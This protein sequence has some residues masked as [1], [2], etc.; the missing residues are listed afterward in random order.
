IEPFR[1]NL[2]TEQALPATVRAHTVF[3][4]T[5]FRA[6]QTVSM[7]H[8]IRAETGGGFALLPAGQ[9]P[10]RLRIQ[11]QGSGQEFRFPLTWRGR[12]A[13]DS[14]FAIPPQA[15]L[16]RYDVILDTGAVDAGAPQADAGEDGGQSGR[17]WRSGSFRV[18][19]FR[20]PLLQG[21]IAAPKTAQVAPA[22]VPLTLQLNYLNGG[23]ASGL[24]VQVSALLRGRA[25]RFP[26]YEDFS[27]AG[28][29]DTAGEEEQKIVADKLQLRLDRNGIGSTTVR[30]LPPVLA[31]SELLSEMQF[32]D[33]NG[34]IQTVSQA[35][36]LWPAAVVAGIKTGAWISVNK[37]ATLAALALDLDGKPRRRA[38]GNQGDPREA[39]FP[40]QA[41]G[42]RLL[43]L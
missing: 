10:N 27:F 41:H 42:R 28:R 36:P 13:S 25:L 29:A 21:R 18:E 11:H 19:E 5:L 3:D 43:R 2:P 15:K 35:T 32:A 26:G 9:L 4:R 17:G 7:K 38:A 16:G 34:E 33:P 30:E 6:G 22:E 24:P 31:A 12:A 39:Q 14:V 37:R 20:L 1:F 23:G 40:P 8:L